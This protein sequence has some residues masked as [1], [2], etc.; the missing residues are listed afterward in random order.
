M[1]LK[2]TEGTQAFQ[3]TQNIQH[4]RTQQE[5]APAVNAPPAAVEIQKETLAVKAPQTAVGLAKD[6]G[7]GTFWSLCFSYWLAAIC[8]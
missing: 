1:R 2:R 4:R 8:A 6:G 5:E 3:R 7:S